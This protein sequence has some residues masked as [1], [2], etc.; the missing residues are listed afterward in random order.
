MF[1]LRFV[2]CVL[3]ICIVLL[4]IK[5]IQGHVM[6]NSNFFKTFIAEQLQLFL[7]TCSD[8]ISLSISLLTSDS[9]FQNW[10]SFNISSVNILLR[11]SKNKTFVVMSLRGVIFFL[12]F[13][14]LSSQLDGQSLD[15]GTIIFANVVSLC[16]PWFCYHFSSTIFFCCI[17]LFFY[18]RS[19]LWK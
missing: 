15:L 10:A 7:H 14:L 18:W 8:L 11:T 19:L 1:H 12:F 9:S 5:I 16:V 4:L 3:K 13:A 6:Y 17:L 2:Y